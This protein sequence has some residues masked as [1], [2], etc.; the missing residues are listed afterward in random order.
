MKFRKETLFLKRKS[1]WKLFSTMLLISAFKV[2]NFYTN[3]YESL[4][5]ASSESIISAFASIYVFIFFIIK[6][7]PVF[8]WRKIW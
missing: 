7:S 2:S 1:F 6:F 3:L 5:T 8:P 4:L